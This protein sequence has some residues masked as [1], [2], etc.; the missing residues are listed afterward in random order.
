[1][2]FSGAREFFLG[3]W[4]VAIVAT[5]TLLWHEDKFLA[6][7][8]V[9]VAKVSVSKKDV[10]YR[11]ENDFR[12]KRLSS[13][14]QPVFDGD[15]L[16]TGI[17]S[18]ALI[19]FGDGRAASV[20]SESLL[21]LS[22]IKQKSGNTYIIALSRGSVSIQKTKL[23]KSA[24]S[25]QFPIIIRSDGTD[26]LIEP[27]DERGVYRDES[28]VKQFTGRRRPKPSKIKTP[29]APIVKQVEVPVAVV[30]NLINETPIVVDEMGLTSSVPDSQP[31]VIQTEAPPPPKITKPVSKVKSVPIVE[32]SPPMRASGREIVPDFSALGREYYTF[33]SFSTL[34]GDIGLMRWQE[35][36]AARVGLMNST[37]LPSVELTNGETRRQLALPP[38][39]AYNLK[40]SDFGLLKPSI[41]RNGIPCAVLGVRGGAKIAQTGKQPSWSFSGETHEIS[42]CSYRDAV[43]NLPLVI[44]MGSLEDLSDEKRPQIFPRPPSSNLRYQM[45]VTTPSQFQGLLP[46]VSSNKTF[47]I[48]ATQGMASRGIFITKSGKVIMQIAGPGFTAQGADD[49]RR[50]I[51]GDLV[52]K[53]SRNAILETRNISVDELKEMVIKSDAQ[54]KKIYLQKSGTLLPVSRTFLEERDEVASFVK[55]VASQLFTERVEIIAYK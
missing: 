41:E 39:G 16:A 38:G 9:P 34:K 4:L 51:G 22:S 24:S 12:W 33:Q 46:L 52:F 27:G 5:G 36:A 31:V 47:R 14:G 45:I 30:A 50:K 23:A 35:P 48:S 54:G 44:S 25:P 2:V 6:V 10:N 8:G 3:F 21:A 28:G 26:Y 19:D 7:K 13:S 18:S 15:K 53:G 32:K 1:V 42:I 40:I 49:V 20:G 29:I 37:W 17:D 55:S 11:G 43:Q